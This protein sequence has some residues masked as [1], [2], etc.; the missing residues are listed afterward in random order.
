MVSG[1]QQEM[2]TSL[3]G[4]VERQP[5]GLDAASDGLA[6]LMRLSD[7]ATNL[8]KLLEQLTKPV[9]IVPFVGAGMSVPLGYPAWRPFLESQVPDEGTR[10]RGSASWLCSMMVNTKRQRRHC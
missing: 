2:T 1:T 8:Q 9:G 5:T 6:S 10:G 7:N 4:M 3:A